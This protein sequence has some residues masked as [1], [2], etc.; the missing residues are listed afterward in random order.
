[1]SNTIQYKVQVDTGNSVKSLGQL[2]TELEQINEALKYVKPGS[3]AFDELA[4][5]SQEA[6]KQIEK[7]NKEVEG[8][9]ADK[10]FQA[11]DGAIKTAAGSLQAFVGGLGLLGIESDALGK[12]EEKAASAIAVGIGFKDISEGISQLRPAFVLA[13]NAAKGFS[14]TTKRA[15]IATGIGA[16]VVALGSI[17]A[18]WDEITEAIGGA[19]E[20]AK[21][22]EGIQEDLVKQQAEFTQKVEETKNYLKLAEEGVIS[23]EEAL[24]KYNEELGESVGFADD[25]N[26]AEQLMEKNT[27]KVIE[28]IRL[29]AE[30]QALYAKAAEESAK[31]AAG[32]GY[33]PT[34]WQTVG[35]AFLSLGNSAAF[36]TRQIQTTATN[37]SDKQNMINTLNET[38]NE[39]TKEAIQ[40]EQEKGVVVAQVTQRTVEAIPVTVRGIDTTKMQTQ[41]TAEA[42]DTEYLLGRIRGEQTQQFIDQENVKQQAIQNGFMALQALAGE[43]KGFAIANVIATQAQ[44]I[45]EIISNTGIANAKAVAAF[46]LTAGQPWVG[47]NTATAGAS[48]AASLLNAK[49]S[50]QQITSADSGASSIGGGIPQL[51]RGGSSGASA[52]PS[53]PTIS[54]PSLQDAANQTTIEQGQKSETIRAYVLEGDVSNSQEAARKIR[55]RRTIGK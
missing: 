31:L 43:S 33:E 19:S 42:I 13:G 1:M 18:Y 49:R 45:S 11:A 4:K 37:Y 25:L 55:Q 7:I 23:K 51:P 5:A 35:D 40:L 54:T 22:Y 26:Q 20:E 36:A 21:V 47:I 52:V 32:E 48:I 3:E 27:A 24:K 38:A 10:K 39:K 44:A 28:Q 15:L 29:R 53:T 17:V 6:T 46:P 2:E 50:I 30:A 8:F 12:F 34:F 14:A 41:V 9:T 16:F